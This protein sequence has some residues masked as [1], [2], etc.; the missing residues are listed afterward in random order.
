MTSEEL[1][2]KIEQI[3]K[4]WKETKEEYKILKKLKELTK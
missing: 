2:E 1:K 3:I 4:D